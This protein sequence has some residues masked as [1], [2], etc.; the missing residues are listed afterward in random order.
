MTNLV[1]SSSSVASLASIPCSAVRAQILVQ[2]RAA[3]K[4]S[5]PSCWDVS[6]AGHLSAGETAENAA[7][8][9]LAEE[10]GIFKPSETP[11]EQFFRP[12]PTLAREVISQGGTRARTGHDDAR[13]RADSTT[14]KIGVDEI[15]SVLLSPRLRS[16]VAPLALPAGKFIDREHTYIYYVEGAFDANEMRLQAEEVEA[17]QWIELSE[18]VSN[19][20]NEVRRQRIARMTDAAG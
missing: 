19:M 8:A 7:I 17:V 18:L 12:L 4:D 5:F 11:F 14:H 2:K 15:V 16:S 13:W 9:E 3:C 20:E 1:S 6:C 10:L